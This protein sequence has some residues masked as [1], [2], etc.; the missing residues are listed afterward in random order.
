MIGSCLPARS[1]QPPGHRGG[2]RFDGATSQRRSASSARLSGRQLR[3]NGGESSSSRVSPAGGIFLQNRRMQ[4][5]WTHHTAVLPQRF[6]CGFCNTIVAADRGWNTGK[7]SVGIRI[8]PNCNRPT[9]AEE[10]EQYPGVAFG[11]PVQELPEDISALYEEA[12]VCCAGSS[13]TAAVLVLRK[14][15]MNIAVQKEAP[16]NKKFIEYV[17]YLSE[18]GYVPPDGRSWVNYIRQKGNEA[19]H[20]IKLMNK[21]DAEEL[22]V[23]S[24]MLLKFIYEFPGLMS[25]PVEQ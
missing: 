22:V 21:K 16:E 9:Y 23:F 25:K 8:C 1:V 12:R 11:N 15:L 10:G 17:D 4:F 3:R 5:E 19:T 6:K 13:Y 18:K 20:E 2:G 14:L 7:L 24:E